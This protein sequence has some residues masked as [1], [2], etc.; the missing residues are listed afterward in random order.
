MTRTALRTLARTALALAVMPLASAPARAQEYDEAIYDALRWQ[1]V[2]P[3]RGGR[4]TAVAGSDA[5]PLEFY[6]GATGGGLWKTTDGGSNW[7][8]MTAGEITSSSVG[9]AAV[10]EAGPAVVGQ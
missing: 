6:F 7:T 2:G 5:R 10:V 1:N 8:V 9:A 3:S 4:S